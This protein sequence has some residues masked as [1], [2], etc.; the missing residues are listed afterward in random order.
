M[1]YMDAGFKKSRQTCNRNEKMLTGNKRTRMDD[2]GK[3]HVDSKRLPKK[4]RPQQLQTY[5]VPSNDEENTNDTNRDGDLWFVNKPTAVPRRNGKD[6]ARRREEQESCYTLIKISS[7][8]AKRDVR[9]YA[10]LRLTQKGI[11]FSA[12]KL[13]DRLSQNV[14]Y[15]ETS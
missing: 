2:Q 11:W 4:N 1:A 9:I 7:W 15:Q 8:K 5:N 6:A 3:A 14:Q 12:A 10:W 13:L